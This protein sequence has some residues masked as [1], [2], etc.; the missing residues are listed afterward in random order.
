MNQAPAI[1]IDLG[2]TCSCVAVY[3]NGTIEIVAN[4]Q[5]NRTTP[6]IIGF[7]EEMKRIGEAAESKAVENSLNTIFG[8]F[9]TVPKNI[10]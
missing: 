5:G 7:T 6:S 3:R 10:F 8:N 1:G 9:S 2:T 4:E